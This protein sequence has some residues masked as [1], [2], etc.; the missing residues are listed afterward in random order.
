MLQGNK[1]MVY[2][3]LGIF[4]V[5]LLIVNI[6]VISGFVESRKF[7]QYEIVTATIEKAHDM[8]YDIFESSKS[9]SSSSS[10]SYRLSIYQTIEIGFEYQG[11]MCHETLKDQSICTSSYRSRSDAEEAVDSFDS[12]LYKEGGTVEVYTN[13]EDVRT[14]SEVSNNASVVWLFVLVGIDAVMIGIG[15]LIFK[16]RDRFQ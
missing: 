12:M 7:Q 9:N 10:R 1:K 13:G 2:A 11:K 15:V 16:N 6:N 5:I 14:V 3:I 4:A 8:T